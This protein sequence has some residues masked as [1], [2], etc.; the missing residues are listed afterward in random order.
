MYPMR[1]PKISGF[2]GSAESR[3][4]AAG[5]RRA[6]PAAIFGAKPPVTRVGSFQGPCRALF[7]TPIPR[8]SGIFPIFAPIR[9]MPGRERRP[10]WPA[11][12]APSAAHRPGLPTR[13]AT[14]A[15]LAAAFA[16]SPVLPSSAR[17][18]ARLWRPVVVGL[19]AAATVHAQPGGPPVPTKPALGSGRAGSCNS[20][21][22]RVS[23]GRIAWGAHR[24]RCGTDRG[25]GSSVAED[26]V[27]MHTAT[28]TMATRPAI[29]KILMAT[30]VRSPLTI[31]IVSPV[32]VGSP[33][34]PA[35]QPCSV[36]RSRRFFDSSRT[37][38]D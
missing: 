23:H 17:L 31:F 36:S 10:R 25:A 32:V 24:S 5:Q 9:R 19:G 20:R 26:A 4:M 21:N 35:R 28:A 33:A 1:R 15:F 3:N 27:P 12:S 22:S 30:A 16:P 11:R 38:Y 29:V 37:R 34:G 7:D 13:R 18:A 8:F 6:A 14:P 2:R